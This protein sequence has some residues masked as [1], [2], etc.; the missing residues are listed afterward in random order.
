M[1]P[2]AELARE[3]EGGQRVRMAAFGL[4]PGNVTCL[5]ERVEH[6]RDFPR[7][8]ALKGQSPKRFLECI[9]VPLIKSV[10]GGYSLAQ[11]LGELAQLEDRGRGI[12]AEITLRQRP[13]PHKLGVV[14]FQKREIAG[15]RHRSP[16]D[17][18]TI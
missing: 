16:L 9:A 13:K 7:N 3:F 6:V 5:A 2:D 4:M 8:D 17:R 14:H 11:K 12:I 10:A 18:W 15:R 1:K